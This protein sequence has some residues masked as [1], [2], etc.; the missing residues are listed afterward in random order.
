MSNY[1]NL[2]KS[3]SNP[4]RIKILLL[5]EEK[6][7][8]LTKLTDSIKSYSK[9]E[10]SRH[11]NRLM[12]DEFI[13]K[14]IPLGKNYELTTFGKSVISIFKPLEFILQNETFFKKHSLDDLPRLPFKLS[15]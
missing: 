6:N 5:L 10:I 2:I 3:L 9:S 15:M 1:S 4:T 14:E 11:L 13:Q 7:L 12:K 8:T